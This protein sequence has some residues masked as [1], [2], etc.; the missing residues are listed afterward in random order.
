METFNGYIIMKQY[1]S[2]SKSDGYAAYLYVAPN[3][4]FKLYRAEELASADSFFNAFHLKYV[5]VSGMFHQRIRSIKVDAI[6]LG[7]D[8]FLSSN[9]VQDI[10]SNEEV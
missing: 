8:P 7:N 4:V 1:A 6:E 5:T 9:N 3:K 2:G 10:N